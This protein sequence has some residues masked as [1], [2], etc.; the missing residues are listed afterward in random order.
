MWKIWTV[1]LAIS[2]TAL[3]LPVVISILVLR[4][5]LWETP[6]SVFN[7]SRLCPT[8]I[9]REI[10]QIICRI[11]TELITSWKVTAI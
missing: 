7:A 4:Y 6:S 11:S 3:R 1:E 2:I 9:Y 8:A 10:F 5:Y